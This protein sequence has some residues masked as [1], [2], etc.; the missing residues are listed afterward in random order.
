MNIPT[1]IFDYLES[2]SFDN[3]LVFDLEKT[4]YKQIK[5]EKYLSDIVKDKSVLHIGCADHVEVI[6]YKITNNLWLHKELSNVASDC[7]GIDINREAIDYIRKT[8]NVNNVTAGDVTKDNIPG[9][10][11]KKWDYVLFGEI[12]EHID[13]P[14]DFLSSF[15]SLYSKNVDSFIIT[16]PNILN[17]ARYRFMKEYKEVINS[18]HRFWFTPYTILKVLSV[19]GYKPEEIYFLNL[20]RL[21]FFELLARK[22]KK[23][24]GISPAYPFMY[25]S[26]ILVKGKVN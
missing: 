23:I 8:H 14:V 18:D 3:K 16:V 26:T 11:E 4:K 21:S 2:R 10:L 1:D 25:F 7:L 24:S 13:N 5:R 6:D 22:L 12:L 19:S 9:I 17:I 20:S 15:K